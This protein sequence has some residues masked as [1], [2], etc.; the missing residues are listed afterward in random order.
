MDFYRALADIKLCSVFSGVFNDYLSVVTNRCEESYQL[1]G[2]VT[3]IC[4]ADK[5]WSGEPAS[6]ESM[7]TFKQLF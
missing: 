7:Y 6:C 4:Q 3:N 2:S 5:T 1:V